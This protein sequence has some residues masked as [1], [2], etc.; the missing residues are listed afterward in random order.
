MAGQVFSLIITNTKLLY[1][2]RV[3]GSKRGNLTHS[4]ERVNPFKIH[5][6]STRDT[7]PDTLYFKTIGLGVAE[8]L[9]GGGSSRMLQNVTEAV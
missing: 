5:V 8:N 7:S 4:M 3:S 9:P 2:R 1:I 6:L